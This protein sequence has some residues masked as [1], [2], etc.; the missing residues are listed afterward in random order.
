MDKL[1]VTICAALLGTALG[2]GLVYAAG[3]KKNEET[4]AEVFGDTVEYSMKTGVVKAKGH[5]VMK[6]DGATMTGNE[7]TYNTKSQAGQVTGNVVADK[8]DLHMT[9]DVFIAEQQNHFV[10]VGNVHARQKDKAYDGPKAEY[11]VDKDYVLMDQG[12]IVTSADGTFQADYMEGW[13][14]EEHYKG[15]GNAHVV[16]PPKKFE[17]GGDEAEYFGKQNGK[18]ILTGNAWAIQ[19]GNTLKSQKIT[20]FLDEQEKVQTDTADKAEE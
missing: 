12:G 17:G 11:F 10:A 19:E 4:P 7:A 6:K 13:I 2:A 16:S 9:S 20:I 15:I 5:V 18:A 3:E 8:E 14:K 1:K